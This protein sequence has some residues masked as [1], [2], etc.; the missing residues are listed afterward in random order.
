M[1][2]RSPSLV[3]LHSFVAV[4]ETGN[5]T[6]AAERLAVTQGAVSRAVLRLEAH[7]GTALFE[8]GGGALQATPVGRQ[9]YSRVQPAIAELEAAVPGRQPAVQQDLNISVISSFNMRWLVPRLPALRER[10]PWLRLVFK[11]YWLKDDFLR[12][13]VDCWIET[14]RTAS[15]RWPS[16]VRATYIAGREIV[17]ICHPS[18]ARFIAAPEDVLRQPLLHHV[19]YPDNWALW[20]RTHGVDAGAVRLGIGFDL[21]VGMI[22]AVAANM[23][24]AVVQRCLIDRELAEGRVVMP[25]DKAANTGRGYYLCVP[26]ARAESPM[27]ETFRAWLLEQVGDVV[28]ENRALAENE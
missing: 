25:M 26:R 1:R 3:E 24:I 13:D 4:I 8:R 12:D 28:D 7:L 5:L 9:Y 22:E 20:C 15:S 18:V 2:I 19:D 23:G 14:R 16:H 21:A 10:H 11:P 27:L 17:P 6:R